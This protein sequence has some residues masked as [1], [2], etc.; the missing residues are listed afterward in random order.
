MAQHPQANS[1]LADPLAQ[2]KDVNRQAIVVAAARY[3]LSM[4]EA[5]CVRS[6]CDPAYCRVRDSLQRS[7]ASERAEL[8]R[9]R[10]D[11]HVSDCPGVAA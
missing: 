3:W 1:N 8:R 9:L 6:G 11:Q 5:A 2:A 7:L 4:V 10:R